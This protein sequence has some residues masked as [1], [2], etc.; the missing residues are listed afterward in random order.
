MIVAAAPPTDWRLVKLGEIVK[1][2]SRNVNPNEEP[3]RLWN[4]VALENVEQG[5]GRL[6]EFAPS[7]GAQIG[8][9]KARFEKGDVLYGKLRPYLRKAWVAEFAGCSSTDLIPLT[10]GPGVLAEYLKWFLL[11][12][13]HMEYVTPLMAGIRMPRLRSDDLYNMPVPVPPVDEQ[14]RIVA[15]IQ[16]MLERS[17][18]ARGALTVLP[19]RREQYRVALY[20]EAFSGRL[21]EAWRKTQLE[22]EPVSQLLQRI[23]VKQTSRKR[24]AVESRVIEGRHAMAVGDPA[25]PLPPAWQWVRLLDVAQLETGHTPSRNHPEYWDGAIP[26]IGIKDARAHHGGYIHETIQAVTELGIENSAARVLPA[27]TVCLS[28]TASVG[29]VCIMGRSMATSQDF[30]NWICSEAIIPEYLVHALIAEGEDIRRFGKG[31]T[32]T[33]IY[34]PEVMS[35]HIA[36]PPVAEQREIV[37]RIKHQLGALDSALRDRTALLATD[38]DRLEQAILAAAFVGNL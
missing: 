10:P 21:T 15:R 18:R 9:T 28:R 36:L 14:R 7:L 4:Y 38:L 27:G 2:G 33:T 11:S 24:A 32:H 13:F 26:W 16:E 29:Y 22:A 3:D 34:F 30:V 20:S 31:S 23:S 25:S 5:T 6:V 1:I 17:R 19:Q 37:W 8:S 35:F 12:P